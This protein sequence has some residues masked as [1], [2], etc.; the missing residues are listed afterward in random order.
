MSYLVLARKY[1][2]DSFASVSGQEHVTRTLSNAIKRNK[3]AHAYLFC[4]PRGVGKTSIARIFAK[5]LNCATGP[6]DSPCLECAN[7]KEIS[8]GRSL[9]VLE[10]DGASHNSV[11]NV[12]DL[13]DSFRSAPPPGS[14]YKVYI[15]DEVHMLSTSAFNALLKS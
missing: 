10:I 8:D 5:S 11:D 3:V 7:C 1:R 9:A 15:I 13:I 14:T 2:P 12:R 4:G 6:T